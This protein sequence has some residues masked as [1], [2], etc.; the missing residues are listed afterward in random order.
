MSMMYEALLDGLEVA[1]VLADSRL[2]QTFVLL[3]VFLVGRAG[4]MRLVRRG[5]E[6]VKRHYYWNSVTSYA[7][8]SI[9]ALAIGGVWIDGFSEIGTFLG[10][11]S[12]GLAIALQGPLSN[13]AGWLIIVGRRPFVVGDRIEFGGHIGDV[14]DIELFQTHVLECGNWVHSEQSNGRMVAIPNSMVL[15]GSVGNFTAGFDHVWDEIPVTMT[16][17]SDW[18]AAKKIL[19][20]ICDEH[21][22]PWSAGAEEAVKQASGRKLIFYRNFTPIVYTDI[23]DSG[24]VLTLRY[25]TPTRSR[26]SAK[27]TLCEAILRAFSTRDDLDLAYPTT[28]FYDN[29]QE[30]KGAPR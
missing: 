15:S 24:I 12:A 25:M 5:V 8:G 28:R 10:L 22:K 2:I 17:E 29:R 7:I 23:A 9:V 26:R 3:A 27:Q 11:F 30:G 19:T 14:I 6:D 21:A 20:D 16:F 1:R 18:E 13:F 4:V